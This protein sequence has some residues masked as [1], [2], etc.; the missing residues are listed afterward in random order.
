MKRYIYIFNGFTSTMKLTLYLIPNDKE[1]EK[2]K[3]FLIANNLYFEE[4]ILNN[5]TKQEILK[6][7][8]YIS[9]NNSLLLIV[10][11]H[12][13]SLIDGFHEHLLNQLVEHIQKYKP[14]IINPKNTS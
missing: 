14:K 8:R 3:D 9:F 11:S 1:G 4:K 7:S 13:I 5:E 12:S 6:Y 10:K 2:I